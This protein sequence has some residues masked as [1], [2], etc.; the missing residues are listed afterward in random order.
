M[1]DER[2]ALAHEGSLAVLAD[3]RCKVAGEGFCVFAPLSGVYLYSTHGILLWGVVV[4][5]S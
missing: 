5:L 1:E 2:G 3:G 4:V